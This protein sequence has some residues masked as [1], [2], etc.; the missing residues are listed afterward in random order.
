M[1]KD[2]VVLV[3]DAQQEATLRTLL[4]QRTRLSES[5]R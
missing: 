3:A 5:G 2:L 4:A 1:S